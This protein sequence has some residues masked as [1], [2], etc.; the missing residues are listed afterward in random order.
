MRRTPNHPALVPFLVSIALLSAS[1]S[2]AA[3]TLSPAPAVRATA[4]SEPPPPPPPPPPPNLGQGRVLFAPTGQSSGDQ[5]GD[6]VAS[7]GDVN[8]DGYPDVIVGGWANDA[9]GLDAGAAYVFFGGPAADDVPDLVLRGQGS[10]DNFGTSVASAGDVNGDGYGDLIVGAWLS[11]YVSTRTGRAY[12]YFGGPVPDALPDLILQGQGFGDHFGVSVASAGDVNGDGFSDVIVGASENDA[13]G[14]D[15][16]R[17]YIYLGGLAPNAVADL[18][19]TGGA[20]GDHFGYAVASAKDFNGDGHPDVVVGAYGAGG[21]GRA[22][23]FYGGPAL[24]AAPDVTFSGEATGDFFGVSVAPAGDVDHDGHGDLIVGAHQ[25]D[26]GGT[27]AG[28]AYVFHGGPN[29]DTSADLVLTGEHAGDSFGQS[30][31]SAGDM[32]GDGFDDVIVGAWMNDTGA[33][34]AGRAYVYFGGPVAETSPDLTLT[35]LFQEDRLGVKVD[36]VGDFNGDGAPD[37]I[38]AAYF[39][40]DA[41]AEAGRAYIV[42]LSAHGPFVSAPAQVNGTAGQAIAFSATASDPEGDAIASFTAAPLPSGAAFTAN[43]TNTSGAFQWTPGLDQAGD[44][45]VIFTAVN[46][47]TGQA[48]TRITVAP[49]PA[50][51]PPVLSAPASVF[52]AEGVAIAV[53]I[54]ATD[55]DGDHVTLG[56]TNRPV[57]SLFIDQ[58]NNT[59]TFGWTPSFSQAGSYTVTF[60]GRDDRGADAAPRNLSLSIDNVDRAPLASAGGPYAGVVQVPVTFNGTGS[61]DPDGTALTFHWD[62]G[63]GMSGSGVAPQHAYA[64]G[65]TFA[66]TVTVD[67]G[68]L[69]DA[70]ST[71]ATIQD[72]FPARAY[73][74]S[75]YRTIKLGSGKATWC[76]EIEPASGSFLITDV[77]TST[78]TM[79]YGTGQIAAEPGQGSLGADKDGNG[80]PELTSCFAK[81]DLRTLFA[82]L[83]KGTTSVSVVLQGALVTG[84]SFRTTLTVEVSKSGGQLAASLSPNP[85]NP[86]ATLT[87]ETSRPGPVRIT[88]FDAQGRLVRRLEPGAELGAGYH[89]YVVDG[90]GDRGERLPSGAYLYR[91][92]TAERVA[93]GRFTIVK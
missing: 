65:G 23:V 75:S 87:F 63:D 90:R 80:V 40:D 21:T 27:N 61:S 66:V 46:D 7:A 28:R 74:L 91:I 29:P 45:T 13:A 58:G 44:Y 6:A 34:N 17:A 59:G 88:I 70:A 35:G 14:T 55:P 47:L 72:V 57:G 89:D 19:L 77:V 54:T 12:I 37:V 41:G 38:V 48:T 49:A 51:R 71:I 9:N 11:S 56:A 24:D 25:N 1:S 93:T 43:A 67:D 73:T 22:Y 82:G 68:E 62:F 92:E 3:V 33:F 36:G 52:G 64:A 84:G 60:T 18:T 78:V 4:V 20:A 50:N 15:A 8:G 10:G 30:V 81:T 85:L 5:F 76:A 42:T 53:T 32:D 69:T 31:A 79:K 86:S 26:A 83:P 39:N 2:F 16:G